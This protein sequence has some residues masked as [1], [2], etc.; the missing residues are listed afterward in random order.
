M[1]ISPEEEEKEVA[2]SVV[3]KRLEEAFTLQSQII[4]KKK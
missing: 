1:L 4:T 3:Y 2:D